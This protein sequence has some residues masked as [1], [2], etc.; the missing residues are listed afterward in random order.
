MWSDAKCGAGAAETQ[1]GHRTSQ[2]VAV[3]QSLN[4]TVKPGPWRLRDGT[5]VSQ[6]PKTCVLCFLVKP[7]S[8]EQAGPPLLLE[9]LK[10]GKD[11]GGNRKNMVWEWGRRGP[12]PLEEHGSRLYSQVSTSVKQR[13]WG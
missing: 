12:G 13:R 4:S 8:P 11:A 1:G 9:S 3:R 10:A 6:I 5:P 7:E 2:H